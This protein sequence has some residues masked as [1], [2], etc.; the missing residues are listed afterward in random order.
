[1]GDV[2]VALDRSG[3]PVCDAEVVSVKL[4]R[5]MDKTALLTFKVP[6]S[7]ANIAR[8]YKAQKD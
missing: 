6:G 7:F 5:P 3:K 4:T 8:F 2:G 1:M